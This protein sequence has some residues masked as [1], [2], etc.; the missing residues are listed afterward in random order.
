MRKKA[1][2]G[3]CNYFGRVDVVGEK[4]TIWNDVE[5]VVK[6][7][8]RDVPANSSLTYDV[9]VSSDIYDWDTNWDIEGATF[10]K[11]SVQSRPAALEQKFPAFITK[12]LS[13]SPNMPQR[14]YL[15]PVTA[16]NLQPTYIRG[17]WQ[18][19]IPQV[20]YLTFAIGILVLLT[21]CFNFM[22][23]A[24]ARYLTT[25]AKEVGVRKVVGASRNQLM[26][27]FLGE[28]VL[29]SLVAF[30]IALVFNEIMRPVF[31]YLISPEASR[32]GPELWQDP[33]LIL[34][35][36]SIT[37]LIGILA[38]SYPALI[39]S[40]L[41]PVEIFKGNLLRGKKA[42][43]FR[44]LLIILQFTAAIF[45]VLTTLVAFNQH[46]HLLKFDVGYQKNKVLVVPLGTLILSKPLN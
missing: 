23:L 7:I 41:T 26:G 45:F 10:L 43:H 13:G 15:L 31:V 33:F 20:L 19:E 6:G 1:E 9:L 34:Q 14:L 11:L 4:F 39:L 24:T 12:Y 30:P 25:R 36:L 22:N 46:N 35:L 40:R 29:L 3:L 8:T 2:F 18:Q 27:Q 37:V 21:V 32:A 38:G 16:M 17:L 44:Q 5:F 42:A 28:S